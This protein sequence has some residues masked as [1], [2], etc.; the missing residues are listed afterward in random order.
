[1]KNLTTTL[2]L[3]A[4]SSSVALASPNGEQTDVSTT[5]PSPA[6]AV[7]AEAFYGFDKSDNDI[8]IAGVALRGYLTRK[9]S[10]NSQLYSGLF[11]AIRAGA[12]NDDS[13]HIDCDA[14]IYT[15]SLGADF[16]I[17]LSDIVS[18]FARVELGGYAVWCDYDIRGRGSDDD[19]SGGAVY[20]AGIGLQMSPSENHAITIAVDYMRAANEPEFNVHGYKVKADEPEYITVSIGYKYTF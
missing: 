13:S 15:V 11:V 5:S 6:F 1:M 18:A 7:S 20:S 17:G 8:D 4:L 14:A 9:E 10:A 19:W 3:L 2:S 12:G 16:Q